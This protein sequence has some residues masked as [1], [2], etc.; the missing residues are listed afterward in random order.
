MG[1]LVIFSAGILQAEMYFPGETLEP[2]CAPTDMNCGVI[3]PVATA[4]TMSDGSLLFSTESA[5]SLLP[6][7]TEGQFL[8]II[9]GQLGW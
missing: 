4:D 1:F 5:W 3:A 7:G 9:G 6:I 8:K 2:A